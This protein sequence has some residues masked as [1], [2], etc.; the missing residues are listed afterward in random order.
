MDK[1]KVFIIAEAGVNHNGSVLLAKEMIDEAVEF[2]AD[3]IKFQTYIPEDLVTV[4]AEKSEYQYCGVNDA[5]TQQE[6]L[7]GLQISH[8]NFLILYS[9]CHDKNIQF[10][11]TAFDFNSLD[12]LFDLGLNLF[13][14]PSG[15]INNLPYLKKVAS[16]RKKIILS[17]GM[18]DINE[19]GDAI[20]ILRKQRVPADDIALLHC[21]TAYPTPMKDV[22]LLAMST[23]QRKFGFSTGYSDHSQGIEVAIAAVALGASIIEKH[24]TLDRN[25]K[26]PD[27][28]TSLEPSEFE[29]MITAIRNV[30]IALGDGIKRPRAVEESNIRVIRK[31]IVACRNIQRGEKFTEMNITVKR[32]GNG[33]SPMQWETI[34][35]RSA[36]IDYEEDELIAPIELD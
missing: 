32:P 10:L 14:V 3:A 11:S 7:K 16:F 12:F 36:M 29:A 18:A 33:I 21:T 17:T 2:K 19:V 9:Y 1:K 20:E 8:E 13:K 26:G 27:H 25:M 35:G 15:E 30:E 5:Q 31:S 22:N 28:Q 24:F 34:L 4:N 23:L 6:M